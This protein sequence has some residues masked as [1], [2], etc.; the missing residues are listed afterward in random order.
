MC[1]TFIVFD[2]RLRLFYRDYFAAIRYDSRSYFAGTGTHKDKHMKNNNARRGFTLIEL[3]VVVLIIGILAAVALPQYQKAVQKARLAEWGNYLNAF[4]KGINIWVL[5]N[6]S[7][8]EIVRFSG[9]GT[10]TD[11]RY[12]SL[13]I[14]MPCIK[15]E[16]NWCYTSQGRFHVACE[17]WGCYA[18]MS[19]NYSDYKGWLPKN[20]ALWTY[21]SI[22]KPTR[23]LLNKVPTATN[24]RKT[25]CQYWKENFSTAQMTADVRTA[26]AEVGVE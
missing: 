7:P 20:E 21:V 19:T 13:N 26:C 8:T 5:E 2:G 3:L 9:D 12:A 11:A 4:Y 17:S 1:L 25:V 15:N 14:D 24:F 16:E 10:G 22:K 23:I 6:G 18:D